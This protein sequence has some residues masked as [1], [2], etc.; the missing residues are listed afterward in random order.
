MVNILI[1]SW[2]VHFHLA[3]NWSNTAWPI[4]LLKQSIKPCNLNE[5]GVAITNTSCVYLLTCICVFCFLKVQKFNLSPTLA[6]NYTKATQSRVGLVSFSFK[7][8]ILRM[9]CSWGLHQRYFLKKR[10]LVMFFSSQ[11]TCERRSLF[12]DMTWS[13]LSVNPSL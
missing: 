10:Y 11:L 12:Q 3:L 13:F 7:I 4:W 6:L 1:K 2:N 5:S 8:L 9:A